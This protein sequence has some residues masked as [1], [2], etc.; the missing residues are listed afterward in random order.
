MSQRR[1]TRKGLLVAGASASV[2]AAQAGV[3]RAAPSQTSRRGWPAPERISGLIDSVGAGTFVL[4]ENGDRISVQLEPDAFTWR[5]GP[6]P[7][8]AFEVGDEVVAEGRKAGR[9]L[10]VAS[11]VGAVYRRI[12]D[13]VASVVEDAV[14]TSSSRIRFGPR[15]QA[16][17]GLQ[18][19][20]ILS[21]EFRPGDQI[22]LLGRKDPTTGDVVALRIYR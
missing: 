16:Q 17:R 10:F 20:A 8:S 4:V 3:A 22:D 15:T 13:Q 7:L 19:S 9:R 6:E 18:L 11:A 21:S 5:D 1:S 2:L 14:E 12:T